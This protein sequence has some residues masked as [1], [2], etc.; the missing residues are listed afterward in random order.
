[1]QKQST[2]VM[3]NKAKNI[4]KKALFDTVRAN[5]AC[6]AKEDKSHARLRRAPDRT[7]VGKRDDQRFSVCWIAFNRSR[8]KKLISRLQR[9][10][11]W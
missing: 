2:W 7:R 5:S 4:Q 3:L 8:S 10:F 1:M 6:P 9:A 11:I